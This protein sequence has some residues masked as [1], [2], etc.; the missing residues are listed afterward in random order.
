MI[1]DRTPKEWVESDEKLRFSQDTPEGQTTVEFEEHRVFDAD[2]GE[3]RPAW[4][5]GAAE[6]SDV[7]FIK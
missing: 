3:L 6:A 1:Q 7:E 4:P 5:P 2:S